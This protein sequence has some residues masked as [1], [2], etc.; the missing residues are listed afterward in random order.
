MDHSTHTSP[1]P[2]SLPSSDASLPLLTESDDD[3]MIAEN[4]LRSENNLPESHPE[5]PTVRRSS[6]A[7]KQ[8]L[9][10][11]AWQPRSDAL[12]VGG[13]FE[14]PQSYKEATNGPDRDKWQG[15]IDEEFQSLKAKNVFIPV[16]HVPHNRKPIGS[17]WVFTVQSDGRFKARLV[18]QGF[19]QIPGVDYYETYSPIL[20]MDSLRI[21]LAVATFYD[22]EIDQ[23]DV[24]TAYLEGDITEEIYEA[25]YGLK[26]S[27]KAW[28]DK[29]SLELTSLDFNRSESDSR[30]YISPRERCVIG[31]YVDD[32]VICGAKTQ[33]IQSIKDQL[34]IRFPLKDLG[35]IDTVIGWKITR[36][37]PTRTLKISPS[38]YIQDKIR[39][40]GLADAKP[41]TSPLEGYDAI[42]PM[43]DGEPLADESAYASAVGSLGYASNSTR[44]DIAFATSQLGRF[45]SSPTQ[46]HWNA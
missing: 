11:S 46:R 39:S 17:R 26:Q 5:E 27:G 33:I 43:R 34:S 24:K 32:L 22:W 6:R 13:S 8:I 36:D 41:F 25:L 42:Q 14:I 10:R 23:V 15:A 3:D 19:D 12:Y 18:A 44:P 30:I 40:F 38:H 21:L 29:L 7:R 1:T 45:N 4:A 35:K 31:V 16:L 28:Y 37:R 20:R 9:P 2:T